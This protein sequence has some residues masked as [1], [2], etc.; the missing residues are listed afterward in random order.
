M[1]RKSFTLIELLVVIAII[2]IL[3]SML[4]PALSKARAAAQNAKCISNLKQLGLSWI[5]Y[6]DQ[7]D[8]HVAPSQHEH[9]GPDGVYNGYFPRMLALDTG[10]PLTLFI[11]PAANFSSAQ[12]RDFRIGAKNQNTESCMLVYAHYGVNNWDFTFFDSPTISAITKPT[13]C[14]VLADSEASSGTAGA[15]AL[16]DWAGFYFGFRNPRALANA[17]YA[18]GHAEKCTAVDNSDFNNYFNYLKFN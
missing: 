14:V 1:K 2:A 7:N 10:C 15:F 8:D 11:C 17:V 9:I 6:A 5:I 18:D 3:A 16:N 4:L 13:T 12:D